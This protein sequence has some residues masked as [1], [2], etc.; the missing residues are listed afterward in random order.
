MIDL[1]RPV[2]EGYLT[3]LVGKEGF[4]ILEQAPDYE[5]VDEQLAE[6]SGVD[7]N[8]VRRTLFILYENHFATYRR[9]RDND[10]GWLTY[11]WLIDFSN[12][13]DILNAE[14]SKFHDILEKRLK[15]EQNNMF[16]ACVN[17]CGRYDFDF[18]TDYEFIC[19][20]CAMELVF[21]D[22]THIIEQL[23]TRISEMDNNINT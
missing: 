16:Y 1:H 22:N 21:D 6:R 15:H 23:S 13:G 9:E 3:K 17:K 20:V 2:V 4:R 8:T 19:P 7:I 5:I 11:Y 10:S 18:A 12:V 14:M